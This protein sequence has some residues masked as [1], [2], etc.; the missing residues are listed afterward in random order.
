M[1]YENSRKNARL[2]DV[3]WGLPKPE[4]D[5]L[6]KASRGCCAL[7]GLPFSEFSGG[8]KRNPYAPSLDRIDSGAG[9]ARGNVRLVRVQVNLALNEWGQEVFF[10]MAL[11]VAASLPVVEAVEDCPPLTMEWSEGNPPP[12]KERPE[13]YLSVSGYLGSVPRGTLTR[14][15][16]RCREACQAR[17]IKRFLGLEPA[18][19]RV[20]GSCQYQERWWYP[21]EVIAEVADK[22]GLRPCN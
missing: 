6:V 1:I 8:H 11:A 10:E 3:P 14:V 18:Y 19:T 21:T 12:T 20:D 13:G 17:G 5:A 4:Y 9:Y 22:L 7:S 16:V 2:R 15:T